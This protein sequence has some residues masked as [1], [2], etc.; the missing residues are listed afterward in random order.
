[1]NLRR[2]FGLL[3]IVETLIDYGTFEIGLNAFHIMILLKVYGGQKVECGS[4]IVF[5]PYKLIGSCT[6]RMCGLGGGSMVLLGKAAWHTFNLGHTC[7]YMTAHILFSSQARGLTSYIIRVLCGHLICMQRDHEIYAHVWP[8]Y[9]SPKCMCRGV[10]K[11]RVTDSFLFFFPILLPFSPHMS[12][13]QAWAHSFLSL[14]SNKLSKWG[15]LCLVAFLSWWTAPHNNKT[16]TTFCWSVCHCGAAC[17]SFSRA[18][19]SVAVS[20][21]PLASESRWR[22]LSSSTTSPRPPPWSL[23]WRPL[24]EALELSKTPQLNVV[25]R[26]VAVVMVSPHSNRNTN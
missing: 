23:P 4:L 3:N 11:K 19:L 20:R 12:P 2:Y 17:R 5:C 18:S 7:C 8:S 14:P 25:F 22:T 16:N 6:I 10:H 13:K 15:L 21:L 26:R 24:T 9:G 1:M